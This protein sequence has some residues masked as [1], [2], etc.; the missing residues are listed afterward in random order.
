MVIGFN[1][2]SL[3]LQLHF[4]RFIFDETACKNTL[5][6]QEN[7]ATDTIERRILPKMS[8]KQ[9]PDHNQLKNRKQ[10]DERTTHPRIYL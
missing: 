3:S 9:A 10:T 6:R 5:E 7:V 8:S 4:L 1:S 2:K